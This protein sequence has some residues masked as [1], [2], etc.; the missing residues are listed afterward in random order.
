MSGGPAAFVDRARRGPARNEI[1]MQIKFKGKLLRLSVER[2]RLP[3]GRTARIELIHHPGAVLIVPFLAD[4]RVI[5][6]KQYRP[7]VKRTL[8]EAPA[9]TLNPGERPNACARRELI[10]ETGF[11]ADQWQRLG[12]IVPVPGYSTE[13][14]HLFRAQG[15]AP[16]YAEKDPDEIIHP[17]VC[18]VSEIRRLFRAGKIIDAKTICGLAHC[19]CL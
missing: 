11:R 9:G 17:M 2:R 12:K 8:Y 13:I 3:N 15:L 14:I 16:A 18:S 4:D 7:S 10:E 19:G 5:L 1:L 6:L